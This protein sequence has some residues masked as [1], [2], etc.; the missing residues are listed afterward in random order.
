MVKCDLCGKELKDKAGL[1]GHMRLV[2]PA[3]KTVDGHQLEERLLELEQELKRVT[4]GSHKH[5]TFDEFMDCA[6]CS[7]W[8]KS[9]GKRY[10]VV[11]VLTPPVIPVGDLEPKPEPKRRL[12]SIRA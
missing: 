11:P 3:I 6:S 1:A 9:T 4:V 7:G 5:K 8:V 10:E 2:H 12:G